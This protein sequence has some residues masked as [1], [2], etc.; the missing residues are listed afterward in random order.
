VIISSSL[1]VSGGSMSPEE[2]DARGERQ[3]RIFEVKNVAE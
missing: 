2:G 1:R 3:E